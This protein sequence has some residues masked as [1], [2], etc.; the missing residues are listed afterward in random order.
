MNSMFYL[1]LALTNIKKNRKTYFPYIISCIG[2]IAMY[3]I[4][5]VLSIDPV[6]ET[7]RGGNSLKVVLM[8][9]TYVIAFFGVIFLFY[10]NSFLIKRRK[11]EFGLFNILGMEKKHIS[12]VVA[13]ET[14]YVSLISLVVGI[15]SGIALS[16]LMQLLLLKILKAEVS[17]GL[18]IKPTPIIVTLILFCIVFILTFLNTLRQ[19]HLT[20]PIDLLKGSQIGER[21]PKTRW[22]LAVI[23]TICLASAYY[24]SLTTE[25]PLSA[26][27][28]FFVAVILVIIGT[29]LLFIAGSTALLKAL[30]KNKKFYYQTKHF[31]SISGLIYRMKQNAVGLAN[32]CILSTAVL[33][34][35]SSTLSLYIGLEDA[36]KTKY[37]RDITVSAGRASEWQADEIDKV[38][39]KECNELKVKPTNIMNYRYTTFSFLQDGNRFYNEI[40]SNNLTLYSDMAIVNLITVN[41]YNRMTGKDVTLAQDEVLLYTANGEIVQNTIDIIGNQFKIKERIDSL[42]VDSM[43]DGMMLELYYVVMPTED[44]IY[45]LKSENKG[46]TSVDQTN[47]TELQYIYAFD[48]DCDA[49][50]QI[51]LDNAIN[52]SIIGLEVGGRVESRESFRGDFLALYGGLFFLGIFL[53]ILF[54][55]A[56][57]LII[58]YKQISEGYD[59]RERFNIMQ[60]VGMSR[61]EIK[62]SIHSQVL[63]VFFLPLITAGIHVA[64]AFKIVTKLLAIINLTNTALFAICTVGAFLVFAIFYAIVYALT[65]RTY[66]KIVNQ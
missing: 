19:I 17:F 35:L 13:I 29:N 38:I 33:I 6:L 63:T 64:F 31:T 2:T 61:S 20:N 50:T 37:P 51:A 15:L 27:M 36:L 66:Y 23:G 11:K 40:N 8:L 44:I 1:K 49:E 62:K 18:Y 46:E 45:R 60:K 39:E 58:Y 10:T 12:K 59:D 30:R 55:M 54:I 16:K 7:M 25:S 22:L 4:M 21:E 34:M 9:G 43:D 26:I 47:L 32:I 48:V 3:Y 42:N 65:A 56:T 28:L 57:V 24:I 52:D 41:E 53:G 5:Y 14:L